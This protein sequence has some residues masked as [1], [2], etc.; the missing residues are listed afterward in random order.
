MPSRLVW[1]GASLQGMQ[2]TSLVHTPNCCRCKPL[3]KPFTVAKAWVRCSRTAQR[4]THRHP[5]VRCQHSSDSAA[6]DHSQQ[7]QQPVYHMCAELPRQSAPTVQQ[8]SPVQLPHLAAVAG[9]ALC[10]FALKKVFDTPSRAYKENVGDEYDSWTDDGVLEYYWGEHIHLG[11]YT[12]ELIN[13]KLLFGVCNDAYLWHLQCTSQSHQT[14]SIGAC[15]KFAARPPVLYVAQRR[16]D[17]RATRK[18]ILSKP[19]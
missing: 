4:Q 6:T 13:D 5:E 8:S 10:F 3:R 17:A 1:A 19:S 9:V 18:R 12:G 7:R 14:Y 11:Y 16:R 2:E 15:Y